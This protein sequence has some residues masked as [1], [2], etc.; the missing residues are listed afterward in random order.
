M[1][2]ICSDLDECVRYV[3]P[4][5]RV[6]ASSS[7]L[8]SKRVPG[9]MQKSHSSRISITGHRV[10]STAS[11]SPESLISSRILLMSEPLELV[12]VTVRLCGGRLSSA[13]HIRLLYTWIKSALYTPH[14]MDTLFT[15][16]NGVI[17]RQSQIE[18]EHSVSLML[19]SGDMR[20]YALLEMPV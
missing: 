4:S 18:F 15:C 7:L 2:W 10:A 16:T 17:S 5:L 11:F 19:V 14:K 13:S 6:W 3:P 9:T 1:G 20:P 8:W 12:A